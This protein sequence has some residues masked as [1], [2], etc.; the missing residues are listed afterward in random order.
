LGVFTGCGDDVKR[1]PCVEMVAGAL[2]TQAAAFRLD[3]YAPAIHCAANDIDEN[4]VAEL[5]T[6]TVQRGQPLKIDLPPGPYTMV[7]TTY[8]NVEATH[9]TG[10]ACVA[11]TISP[12]SQVC[13]SVHVETIQPGC[14]HNNARCCDPT[15]CTGLPE[16]KDCYDPVCA[17]AGDTCSYA[18]KSTSLVCDG[19][20]CNSLG[21]K[22]QGDCS[23]VCDSG[24]GD[25]NNLSSD[26][27]EHN[28]TNDPE[29]CG[30]CNRPC[31]PAG[32]NSVAVAACSGGVCTSTCSPGHANCTRPTSSKKDDGCECDTPGCCAGFCQIKHDN[33]FGGLFYNCTIP[34]DH[35]EASANDAAKQYDP[36]G[37]TL[38]V[39]SDMSGHVDAICN[40]N[41]VDCTCY[42]WNGLV[43]GTGSGVSAIG[44]ARRTTV[45]SPPNA[46]TDCLP[47]TDGRF[48]FPAWK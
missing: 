29:H 48:D 8:S 26:G 31:S 1:V 27:C 41:S 30:D 12:G 46:G 37:V 47:A 36:A 21:G 24:K 35:S 44:H 13:F 5:Y 33:G 42:T 18:P 7:V 17:N 9:P 34:N 22:C 16:P 28:L 23:L 3:V 19:R 40:L 6:T 15:D 20:C 11:Q 2:V 45:S 4:N 38:P 14:H 39:S 43:T 32:S 10:S 25:C